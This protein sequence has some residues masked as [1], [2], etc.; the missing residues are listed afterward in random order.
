MEMGQ[1]LRQAR[2]EAGLSQR[3]L[4]GDRITRNMLSQIENGTAR[5]SMAT[6]QYL[7]DALGKPVSYFL[8]ETVLTDNQR[9][10]ALARGAFQKKNFRLVLNLLEDYAAPDDTLDWECGLLGY[11]SCL[12]LAE[13]AARE[14]RGPVAEKLLSRSGRFESPYITQE[15]LARRDA[16]RQRLGQ[17]RK[18]EALPSLDEQLLLRAE[19]QLEAGNAERALAL[20]SAVETR[21]AETEYL[22]G[23]AYLRKKD[24]PLALAAFLMAEKGGRG[25]GRQLEEC[26]RELGDFENAYRAACRNRDEKNK[27]V[28]L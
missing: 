20:L 10:M 16:L 8:G 21:T 3:A 5:P 23:L 17:R 9:L 11:L 18:G 14:R 1:L 4:C 28:S 15:L 22:S 25:C 12:E 27:G 7:A 2:Q 19:Q 24:Y 13:T 6:L 26:Y